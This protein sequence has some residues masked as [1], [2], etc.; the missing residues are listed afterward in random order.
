MTPLPP[1]S[2]DP[3]GTTV[4]SP[5]LRCRVA[6]RSVVKPRNDSFDRGGAT[7]WRANEDRFHVVQSD[8]GVRAAVADGAGSS[9][10]LCGAW[11]EELVTR[12]P[13]APLRDLAALDSWLAGF[14][15]TFRGEGVA[16]LTDCA[17]RRSKFVREGSC[18]T[19]TAAWL[20]VDQ[21]GAV[22]DWLAYGDSP[23]MIFDGC[24]ALL[25]AHPGDP[26]T[27]DRDPWLLNWKDVVS[28][29]GLAGGRLRL[30][31]P[32]TVVLAS[33]GIGQ[34][35]LL[36][37]L[38][39]RSLRPIEG[40]AEGR[41]FRLARAI[42]DAAPSLAPP[43]ADARRALDSQQDFTRWIESLEAAGLM[44]NDDATLLVIDVDSAYIVATGHPV[45]PEPEMS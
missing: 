2:D 9:G 26:A 27:L 42:A 12:L 3:V 21:D 22:L 32:A 5:S 40:G 43:L 8:D 6:G 38:A 19:L 33:D 4:S 10:L 41:A 13:E 24:G 16:S 45:E 25:E 44:A 36:R 39:D 34:H 18:A 31:N 20:G 37:A 23:I 1:P 14:A 17:A 11:A 35:L 15:L 28:P 29:K 7:Q 30:P